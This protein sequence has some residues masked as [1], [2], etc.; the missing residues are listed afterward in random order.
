MGGLAMALKKVVK[1]GIEYAGDEG[2][3]WVLA[4][5]LLRHGEISCAG[6]PTTEAMMW[7]LILEFA[8]SGEGFRDDTLL[9]SAALS[10]AQLEVPQP[11]RWKMIGKDTFA[12]GVKVKKPIK[13]PIRINGTLVGVL[14]RGS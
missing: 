6:S 1:Q 5:Y 12:S 4:S 3:G 9:A 11:K 7:Q 10:E 14:A 2:E 8:S 13:L